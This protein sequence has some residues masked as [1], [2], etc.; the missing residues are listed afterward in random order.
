[1]R[2]TPDTAAMLRRRRQDFEG[3]RPEDGGRR[4]SPA[5][6]AG[7]GARL[8]D[9]RDSFLRAG[10][11]PASGW[12]PA[13]AGFLQFCGVERDGATMVQP[14]KANCQSYCQATEGRHPVGMALSATQGDENLAPIQVSRARSMRVRAAGRRV[15]SGEVFDR[16]PHYAAIPLSCRTLD[17]E[18]ATSHRF[19]LDSRGWLWQSTQTTCAPPRYGFGRWRARLQ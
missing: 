1:M 14:R 17:H 11:H 16:A 10:C 13:C 19:P 18:P 5:K 3:A 12:Y 4:D 6:P 2:S 15:E 9:R 8:Y 7:I